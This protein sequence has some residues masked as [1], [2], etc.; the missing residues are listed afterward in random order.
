MSGPTLD[1]DAYLSGEFLPPTGHFLF[2]VF[3]KKFRVS[4]NECSVN[5]A[6][7]VWDLAS[8][9]H[10]L[11]PQRYI[12]QVMSLSYATCNCATVDVIVSPCLEESS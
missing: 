3:D 1:S 5:P 12:H 11:V 4:Q 2:A 6:F 10:S 7:C 9:V 8:C